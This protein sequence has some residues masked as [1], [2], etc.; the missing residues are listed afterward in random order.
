MLSFQPSALR[1]ANTLRADGARIARNIQIRT[2]LA[3][4]RASHEWQSA[5]FKCWPAATVKPV[6]TTLRPLPLVC[7]PS[8]YELEPRLDG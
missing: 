6:P 3:A 5:G 1:W 2:P 8:A 4:R 7:H